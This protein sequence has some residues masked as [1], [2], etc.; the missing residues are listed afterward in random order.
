MRI[1]HLT[2]TISNTANGIV[3][4][5]VDLATAQA[6]GGHEVWVV[7]AGGDWYDLLHAHGVSTAEV[8]FSR[9]APR[10]LPAT[11]RRLR[12][13]LRRLEPDVVHA[14]TLTPAV[15]VAVAAPRVPSVATVH[16][17]FQRGVGVMGLADA[18]VCVSRAVELSMRR[19]PLA[20]RKTCT[21][22]NATIG[23]PR[24]PGRPAAADLGHPAVVAVGS[25]TRRK[26]S[27]V[28]VAAFG[29]V[30]EAH[31]DA[32]LW[33][34]GNVDE[35][36]TLE[37]AAGA[38]WSDRVHTVGSVADPRPHLYGADIA[39]TASRRDPFPL[40]VGEQREAGLA[41]VVSS[42]DGLPEAV[43]HG[44]AGVVFPSGDV[45][46]LART[47]DRLLGDEAARADLGERARRGLERAHVTRMTGEYL[48]VYDRLL[49]EGRRR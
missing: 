15:L 49:S 18:V 28:L 42:A 41:C 39:V 6:A 43:D 1:V 30:A 45:D 35:P 5:V 14:H 34:V 23:S 40:V 46:A 31:P 13:L 24:R 17:E 9:R 25:V 44:A 12:G 26:G 36:D 3:N 19:R 38:P 11:L 21:V 8:D 47:L 29:R 27:D 22:T 7:S 10:E 48:A 2:D 16:N 20:R 4:V 32:Q 37:A 33:F